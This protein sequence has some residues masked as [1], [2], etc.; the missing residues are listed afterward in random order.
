MEET[1]K[2]DSIETVKESAVLDNSIL[3]TIKK[4]LGIP[5]DATEFDQDIIIG[6]N[7]TFNILNQIG[8]GPEKGF[9]I[10]DAST[11]WKDYISEDDD[12]DAVKTYMHLKVKMF[13]DPPTS[14]PIIEA[15][16]RMIR[17]LEWRLN[18]A[19]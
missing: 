9:R 1:E 11:E 4:L 13:F 8:I 15:H 3:N 19:K 7:S 14:G 16:D 6:I 18:N 12:L 17:E 2:T 5:K 10:S